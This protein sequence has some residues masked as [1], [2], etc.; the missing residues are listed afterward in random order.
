VELAALGLRDAAADALARARQL[1]P[2]LPAEV[3]KLAA[4]L[5]GS[6][7]RPGNAEAE[8]IV[9]GRYRLL[10]L[11]GA[12]GSG[13]VYLA[14]DEVSG[15][16]VAVKLFFAAQARGHEAYE[17]FVRE[18]RISGRGRHPN[19]VDV[20]DFRED[21]GFLVMEY[22]SGGTLADRL[23]PRLTPALVRRTALDV[24]AGLSFAHAR[25]IVHRDVKPANVFYDARGAAKLGDFGVAHLLDLGQTQTGGLIGTLAYMSPEQ[26]T[27]ASITVAADLYALGVTMFLALTGRLPFLGPD[28]VAQHLGETPPRP[29]QV[30][31]ELG[32]AWDEPLLRLLEK[33]PAARFAD[34]NEVR[35]IVEA[36]DVERPRVLVLPRRT[37]QPPIAA[38][39]AGA[40]G[41]STPAVSSSSPA[42]TSLS[43][44]PAQQ[45][46]H[47]DAPLGTTS[48]STLLRAVDAA[49][50]RTV[51][52]ERFAEG[53]P[54]EATE[55][56]MYLLAA[57][58]NPHLQRV[59]AYDRNARSVVLE[60]PVGET[61]STRLAA[62]PF[63]PRDVARMVRHLARA[64]A[65]L[66]A[67]GG[68][69][70]ALTA[71]RVLLEEGGSTTLVACGL[72]PAPADLRAAAPTDVM[73]ALA[74][75]AT[76]LTGA[77]ASAADLPAAL[78]PHVLEGDRD[79][80][81]APVATAEHLQ[82]FAD[83][84]EIALVRAARMRA[85]VASL[86][87][88][89]WH[90]DEASR[91]AALVAIRARARA[92]GVPTQKIEEIV[93]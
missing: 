60:A 37:T 20:L 84:L 19:I 66:H 8:T 40:A 86:V 63:A 68:A 82:R 7:V 59:L 3:E 65:P 2:S 13:R 79:A 4:A 85:H 54:D 53:H 91:D 64:L 76:A 87:E 56:R 47:S 43:R 36:I 16:D 15:E 74:V 33:D 90:L 89:A 24:L 28:F 46:Y 31:P 77:P 27:G 61:V 39:V 11:L 29:S 35:G 1:D 41:S 75:A 93:R 17:R 83:A 73:C 25:G 55:R 52:V 69:H 14:R 50:G 49:L 10:R 72:G 44:I 81:S 23:K 6:R 26:I 34:A 88:H 42:D 51:V 45:R 48:I 92:H 70:A 78:A 58:M 62:G 57:S 5:A 32:M 30:V 67:R 9:G 21:L 80:L 38:G 18:A 12:G 22:M 71:D